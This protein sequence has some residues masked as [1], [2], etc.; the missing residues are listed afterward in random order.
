MMH[1]NWLTTLK[2]TFVATYIALTYGLQVALASVPNVET[3][4]L[5]LIVAGVQLPLR[6]SLLIGVCFT[7]LEIITYGVGDWAILY[8]VGWSLLIGLAMIFKKVILKWWWVAVILGSLF[9]F[10]F[11]SLDALIKGMLYG[12]SGLLAYWIQGLIFDLIHGVGN[13]LVILFC[14]WPFTRVLNLYTPKFF[15]HQ[16]TS[17]PKFWW[18]PIPVKIWFKLH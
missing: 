13:F 17:K 2:I 8:L 18:I 5:F 4:T 3:V 11:G 9:G 16:K 1:R 7:S 10:L 6:I 14:Y 15:D 12:V